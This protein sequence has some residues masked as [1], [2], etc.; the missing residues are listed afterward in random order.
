MSEPVAWAVQ[1]ARDWEPPLLFSDEERARR[2][3]AAMDR[4][5][6]PLYRSPT[7]TDAERRDIKFAATAFAE[8]DYDQDCERIAATL[9]GLLERSPP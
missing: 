7:L 3:A 9:R 2:A 6:V 1:G 4:T 5:P 8:N